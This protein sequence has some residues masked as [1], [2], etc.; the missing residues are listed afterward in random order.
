MQQQPKSSAAPQFWW[1]MLLAVPRNR[2]SRAYRRLR[3]VWFDHT[4][5]HAFFISRCENHLSTTLFE[6]F[7]LFAPEAW[8]P[9]L[10]SAAAVNA[11]V[12]RFA[13]CA[14]GYQAQDSTT[15]KMADVGIHARGPA[16]DC[17]I[18]VEAKV[19]GGPL[20]TSDIDPRS[21]LDLAEF[22]GCEQRYLI[23][24]VDEQDSAKT[25][26]AVVNEDA[27]AGFLTW[28]ELGGLQIQLALQL[29]CAED[30]RYFVAS[31]IQYQYL[32]HGI[33]PAILVADYLA[34]EP[35]RSEINA[36]NP[37]KLRVWSTEWR[38]PPPS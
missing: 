18:L 24:L 5:N 36:G 29:D 20:K 25:K 11:P 8:L 9:A 27:L 26:A 33:T 16:G 3:R 15:T 23:Y 28:Q 32:A 22:S 30:I 17:F 10:C 34:A 37:E 38:L 21:Y 13:E 7:V 31:A 35:S 1:E 19:K 14:W 12:D 4:D 2:D 6:N